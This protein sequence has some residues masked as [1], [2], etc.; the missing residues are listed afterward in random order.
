MLAA[1]FCKILGATLCATNQVFHKLVWPTAPE[2]QRLSAK[3]PDSLSDHS[4]LVDRQDVS[5]FPDQHFKL[6]VKT[7]AR[8]HSDHLLY[9]NLY[10]ISAWASSG[11]H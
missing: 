3:D 10:Y 6:R 8:G 9:Y 5:R 2:L 1:V 7:N 4:R 11:K